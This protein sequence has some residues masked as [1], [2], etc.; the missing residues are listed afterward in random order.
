MSLALIIP[1]NREGGVNAGWSLA[2][3]IEIEDG[4]LPGDVVDLPASKLFA[5]IAL[6]HAI[7]LKFGSA[8][9]RMCLA[10]S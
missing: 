1:S 8:T 2:K 5:M 4:A 7:R 10:A 9:P 3:R 6:R